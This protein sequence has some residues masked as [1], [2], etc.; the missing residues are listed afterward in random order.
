MHFTALVCANLSKQK[1]KIIK[2]NVPLNLACT[3][4]YYRQ[5]VTGFVSWCVDASKAAASI[6]PWLRAMHCMSVV[7]HKAILREN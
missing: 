3:F 5:I 2:F 1:R 4:G 7:S 6:V